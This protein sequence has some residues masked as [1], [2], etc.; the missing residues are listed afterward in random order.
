MVKAVKF[1][2][3]PTKL[4]AAMAESFRNRDDISAGKLLDT[5]AKISLQ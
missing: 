1:D 2:A 4:I 5:M 3:D